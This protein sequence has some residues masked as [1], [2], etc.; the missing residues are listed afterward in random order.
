V[1]FLPLLLANLGRKKL[2]TLL[3]TGSFLIA[4]FLFGILVAIRGGFHQG[5]EMAGAD[6]LVVT[7]RTSIIQPLPIAYRERIARIPGVAAVTHA[8]WFGGVYQ[9]EKNFFVQFAVDPETYPQL[10]PEFT[11]STEELAAFR[12]D[13]TG[14]IVGARTAAR[15][16]WK[17]GDRVPLRGTIFPGAWE[18]TIRGIYRGARPEDDLTQ[19]WFQ[20]PYLEEKGPRWIRGI[21]GWYVV[22]IEDPARAAEVAQAIDAAFANSAWET[23]AQTEKALA[24]SFVQ[25][26]GNIEL[27]VLTIGGVVFFT[28]LLVTGATMAGAVRE[29]VPELAVLKALG[30]SDGFVLLLVLAEACLIAGVGGVLGL[31][32]V[33]LFTLRGDPTGGILPIFY[34]GPAAM[35]AG[36]LLALATGVAAA[37][38][39]A[40][41]AMRL[42]VVEAL[43]RA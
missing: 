32:L 9:D 4:L 40:L 43:R 13:R 10:F 21:V 14:A 11:L 8:N 31:G 30:Y 28:L 37:S 41:G 12:A 38:L 23:R 26:M 35:A 25:Q 36:L 17:R 34:V 22:R 18:F 7:N 33:K 39:P 15:F 1:R 6:R 24:G 20:Y 16:G 2:R 42:R 27:L 5:V 29:R 19:F 3:T